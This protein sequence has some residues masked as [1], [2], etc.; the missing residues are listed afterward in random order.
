MPDKPVIVNNG[1][2][3]ALWSIERLDF[4][5]DLYDEVL[6]P[7]SIHDEFLAAERSIRQ[8]TLK[9]AP[10]IKSTS[11]L[12]PRQAMVYTGLDLGEA[13]VLALAIERSARL[14]IM[15]ERKGRQ[16][17]RRL[18]LPLTGTLGVLLAA[19]NKGLTPVVAPLIDNL[20]EEGLYL[21]ADVV[22]KALELAGE[23]R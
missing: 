21:G 3:V 22:A 8:E 5:Q 11:L 1:P 23:H 19:K 6:I 9:K 20:L 12:H 7:K 4:L 17:A 15:D 16:Y 2:L 13:E 14:V 18:K 10:W